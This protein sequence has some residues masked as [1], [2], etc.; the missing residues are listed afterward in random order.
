MKESLFFENMERSFIVSL[1]NLSP[2]V[3]AESGAEMVQKNHQKNRVIEEQINNQKISKKELSIRLKISTT[4]V[5][6]IL[7]SMKNNNKPDRRFYL[8]YRNQQTVSIKISW[9]YYIDLLSVQEYKVA[10]F[11]QSFHH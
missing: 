6:R 7:N 11:H 1:P 4:L 5:Y 10:K 2:V 9:S 3:G 8:T